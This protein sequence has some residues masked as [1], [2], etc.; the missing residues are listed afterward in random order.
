MSDFFGIAYSSE[1]TSLMSG[2]DIK[3]L[4]EFARKNNKKN[5]ITGFLVYNAGHFL[6]YFEGPQENVM[7]L[8]H[9][10]AKDD[11]HNHVRTFYEGYNDHR[12][13]FDWFMAYKNFSEYSIDLQEKY[14]SF[15]GSR[16]KD[17]LLTEPKD[18]ITLLSL[19][20]NQF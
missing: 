3:K 17:E 10:I 7:E 5:S 13:L 4:L 19:V 2:E 8:Y 18:V 16:T 1:S 9:K 20:K 6:Q 12:M 11:R 14:L 15:M